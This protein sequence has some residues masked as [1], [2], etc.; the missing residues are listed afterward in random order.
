MKTNRM[1]GHKYGGME[2]YSDMYPASVK[3]FD[4][5]RIFF[6]DPVEKNP[7][8]SEKTC[9]FLKKPVVE[10]V[11]ISTVKENGKK[12]RKKSAQKC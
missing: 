11:E 6:A 9:I 3:F 12:G 4:F 5:F 8:V 7:N 10:T 1:T 2:V